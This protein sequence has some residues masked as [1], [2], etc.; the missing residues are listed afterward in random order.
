MADDFERM[1]VMF[2][3]TGNFALTIIL[4][5]ISIWDLL[6]F[7]FTMFFVIIIALICSAIAL[8]CFSIFKFKEHITYLEKY[9]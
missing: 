2:Q 5:I 1:I 4:C 8:T 6:L 3:V 7:E 9:S